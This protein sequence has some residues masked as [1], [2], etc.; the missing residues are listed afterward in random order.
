[1]N[2]NWEEAMKYYTIYLTKLNSKPK[3][4]GVE[5]EDVTKKINECN[6]GKTYSAKPERVFVDNLGPSVNTQYPEYSPSITADE[7][8]IIFTAR[9][10]N[11][12]GGKKDADAGYYED[13]YIANKTNGKWQ[14]SKLLSKNVNTEG[15]DASAGLS[16]DGSKLF[17][18][19][20][21]G[22]DGGDL[23]ESTLLGADWEEPVHMNKNINTK[24]HESSVSL[25]FDGKR[26][27]FVSDKTSGLALS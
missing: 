18:Y 14:P 25:S 3:S 24:Y 15:H 20:H 19:R 23:Y 17:V 8:T 6:S 10:D 4:Y 11:S 5:I 12:T 26:I 16:P 13:L 1:M 22:K 21:S 27:F 9:R 7:E 2:G